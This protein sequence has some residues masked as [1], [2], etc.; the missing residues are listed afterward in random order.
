MNTQSHVL[1]GAYFFGKAAPLAAAIGAVGGALP[2][3]PMIAIVVY[4][5]ATGHTGQ[6]I[7]QTLYWQNWWQITNAIAHSFLLWGGLMLIA[8]LLR[9]SQNEFWNLGFVFAASGFLHCC[10]DFCVHREDAHMHFWPLT[11]YKFTSPVSYYDPSHYGQ[12]FSL[13]E[14]A[15]GLFLCYGLFRQ[16]SHVL[17]RIAL[18]LA[19]ALYVAVPAFFILGRN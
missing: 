2:D 10:I 8:F 3:L 13:F 11:R 17:V 12:Y 14:A 19:A 1:M 16:F 9:Q 5:K 18:I 4:L 7:F 6:E 15:L